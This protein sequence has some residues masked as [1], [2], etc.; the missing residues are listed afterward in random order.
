M[1]KRVATFLSNLLVRDDW[2]YLLSLLI[3]LFIYNVGLKVARIL[4]QLS[5]PGPLGFADQ[6]RSDVLFNL[7]YATL[8]IGIFAVFR[9]GILRGISLALF[10]L[11]ALLVVLLTTS[12]HFFYKT[13]G[14]TLDYSFI[15]L[16]LSSFGETY[17]IIASETSTLHWLL[18]SAVLLYL[19]SGPVVITRLLSGRWHLPLRAPGRHFTAS[20]TI[21]SLAL[22]LGALSA[23]PSATG[24][25]NNFSRDT[26]ANIAIAELNKPDLGNPI[27]TDLIAGTLPTDAKLA[28][29]PQTNKRNVVLVL[30][31][32]ARARSTTPYNEDL[33]TTPFLDEL[34]KK[35]LV[36]E[37][38]Y[39]VVPHTSK[40]LVA[41]ICGVPPPL[42]TRNTESEPD[43][44]PAQCLPDL[45]KEQ[46]YNTVSFQSA[47]EKFERRAQLVENFGYED[48]FAIED[49][50]TQGFET[51]NYFGYEDA[52]MLEP[53]RTWL[54]GNTEKPFFAT[55][56]T[57]TS[58]HD[59]TVP[60][61]YGKKDFVEDEELNRYLNTVRYQDFFLKNLFDQYKELGLYEDTIFIVLG[62]HGE[63]FGEH[64]VR[65]H[66][67]VI[68]NEGLR[69][70]FL[71]H[72]PRNHRDRR[73]IETPVNEL[74]VLPTVT[75]LLSYDVEDGTY[76]G[77]SVLGAPKGRTLM[78]SCYQENRCLASIAGSEKY[79]YYYG[80]KEDEFY[81]LSK[82]PRERENIAEEQS[83]EKLKDL[84]D[85]LLTWQAQIKSS[86]EKRLYG[87]GSRE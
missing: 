68:Y 4:A 20:L 47:T 39:A 53:S 73:R 59:Y 66:D 21:C 49:M 19:V 56:L 17:K 32:S 14:S 22:V 5:V 63:G 37:N 34:A 42:D 41:T 80:N 8:W 72:D 40:A 55:Y 10:H 65:Q 77:S 44:I 64:G 26:L 36:A 79:I 74:D 82:D 83:S 3:P 29:T 62:D 67:N 54:E 46:G 76:P 7:G 6:V 13:T 61:R 52:I 18:L 70:P 27:N 38:A 84:R 58:H 9:R 16:S 35:S 11:A 48:F 85:A 43:V 24:A 69:I 15:M 57:V 30:L 51:A 1:K 71:I 87:D 81:D 28:R 12:G 86:Y 25:S 2:V 31:E 45:L 33:K 60:E 78:A 23:L 75:D 50:S